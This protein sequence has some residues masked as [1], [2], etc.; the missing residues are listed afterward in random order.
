MKQ[1]RQ[2]TETLGERCELRWRPCTGASKVAARCSASEGAT[3]WRERQR[4]GDDGV[5]W[6]RHGAARA[7]GR[8]R[9]ASDSGMGMM[10]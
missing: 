9:G 6:R 5:R 8:R 4:H 3:A 2:V 7:R 10:A 1:L